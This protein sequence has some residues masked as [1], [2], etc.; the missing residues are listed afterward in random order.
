M[1]TQHQK[2]HVTVEH[3]F[4]QTVSS[5]Y[6]IERFY[7]YS[8]QEKQYLAHSLENLLPLSRTKKASPQNDSFSMKKNNGQ[9][10][11]YYDNPA[12][13][14]GVATQPDLDSSHILN[15]FIDLLIFMEDG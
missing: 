7:E 4:F 13:K 9:G 1:L 10:M 12:S 3:I 14:N 5:P 8:E 15:C 11:S 2:D 6:W